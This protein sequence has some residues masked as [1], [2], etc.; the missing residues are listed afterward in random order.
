MAPGLLRGRSGDFGTSPFLG[1]SWGKP[2]FALINL[3]GVPNV[4][5]NR[6]EKIS[7]ENLPIIRHGWS[8]TH[9]PPCRDRGLNRKALRKIRAVADGAIEQPD[10]NV[11]AFKGIA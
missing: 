6:V 7:A 3:H 9:L 2:L 5:H 1:S 8:G 4:D 10:S 11:V